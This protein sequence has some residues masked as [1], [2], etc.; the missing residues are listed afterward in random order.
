MYYYFYL[1]AIGQSPWWKKYM[2]VLQ[3]VQFT[4]SFV[5]STAMLY[6]HVYVAPCINFDLWCY[7]GLFNLALFMLFFDFYRKSYT[8]KSNSSSSNNNN[9]SMNVKSKPKSK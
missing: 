6:Q 8:T 4:S 3:L 5:I 2:T 9:R 7:S 1:T